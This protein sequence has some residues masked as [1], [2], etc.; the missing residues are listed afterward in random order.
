MIL[1]VKIQLRY[2]NLMKT[3]TEKDFTGRL[4]KQGTKTGFEKI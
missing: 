3:I 1:D 4:E 2:E